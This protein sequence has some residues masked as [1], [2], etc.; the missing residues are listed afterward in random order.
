MS[1][2]NAD[3][4]LRRSDSVLQSNLGEKS[5]MMDLDAGLYFGLNNVA[6]RIWNLLE[7]PQ[8]VSQL[9]EQLVAEY[10]IDPAECEQK[11]LAFANDLIAKKLVSTVAPD[12]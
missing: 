10:E 3:S 4:R 1:E 6:S 2:L 12:A 11:V 9:V 7:Q 8:T 5:V